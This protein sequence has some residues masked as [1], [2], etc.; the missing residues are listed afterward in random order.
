MGSEKLRK[1]K[2][3]RTT[4]SLPADDH[5]ELEALARKHRVSVAWVIRDAVQKYLEGQPPLDR[6]KL[7]SR[8]EQQ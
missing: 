5:V 1:S 4:I 7:N 3:V 8:G 6:T 2:S